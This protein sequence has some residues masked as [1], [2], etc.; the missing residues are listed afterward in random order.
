M[1]VELHPAY[2]WTCDECGKE[3]FAKSTAPEL[4]DDELKEIR[5]DHGV[6]PWE[7]GVF[8]QVP[9][10]VTCGKCGAKWTTTVREHRLG[11][12]EE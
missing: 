11:D 10:T 7:T 2:W 9:A 12:E 3:A 8:H 1:P 4:T 5:D 6:Q